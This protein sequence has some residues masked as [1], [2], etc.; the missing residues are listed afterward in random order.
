M[1]ETVKVWSRKMWFEPTFW[2]NDFISPK[3]SSEMCFSRELASKIQFLSGSSRFD[4]VCSKATILAFEHSLGSPS[5][6]VRRVGGT[7]VEHTRKRALELF[8]ERH[9]V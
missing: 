4:L 1:K 6:D 3:F 9:D 5:D 2:R 7:G 8:N